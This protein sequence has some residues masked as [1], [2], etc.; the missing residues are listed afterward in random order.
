MASP[1]VGTT[2]ALRHV[3]GHWQRRA[4]LTQATSPVASPATCRRRT[5]VSAGGGCLHD[6]DECPLEMLEGTCGRENV[7]VRAKTGLKRGAQK[8]GFAPSDGD[9]SAEEARHLGTIGTAACRAHRTAKNATRR[10]R[11]ATG[12][13]LSTRA[14]TRRG[15]PVASANREKADLPDCNRNLVSGLA[16]RKKSRDGTFPRFRRLGT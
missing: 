2:R 10:V 14:A 16:G 9:L 7:Q 13:S 15:C 3:A 12:I 6:E 4:W 1:A 11:S 8:R 5:K